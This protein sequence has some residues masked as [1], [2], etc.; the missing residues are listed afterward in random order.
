MKPLMIIAALLVSV[1]TVV[2][3]QSFPDILNNFVD[4]YNRGRGLY[5]PR[6]YVRPGYGFDP[7]YDNRARIMR[8]AEVYCRGQENQL[9]PR[10]IMMNMAMA[11][12][13][14]VDSPLILQAGWRGAELCPGIGR[15]RNGLP[16][17]G[18]YTREAY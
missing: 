2:Q 8:G 5:V 6:P 7:G 14:E 16:F 10:E 1:P 9:F 4:G 18:G 12:N 15:F 17:G 13:V 11:M 3:A